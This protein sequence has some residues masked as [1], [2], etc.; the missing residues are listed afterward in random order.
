M[1]GKINIFGRI[2]ILV[3]LL[4]IPILLLYSISNR[5]ASD[6]VQEQLQTSS[7]NQL[8]FV[9]HQMDL[10]IDNLSMFPV[11]LGQDP[12]IRDYLDSPG[13]A[14]PDMLARQARITEKL[15][16]QSVSSTW[17]NDLSIVL[18]RE[19]KVLSSNIYLNGTADWA[20]EGEV[21]KGWTYE[22]DRTRGSPTGAFVR[23]VAEPALVR[24][25]ES[26]SALYHVSFP[27]RN[28][29]E[30]LDIYKKDRQSEPFLYRP[31]GGM[32]VSSTSDK[33][34]AGKVAAIMA[35]GQTLSAAGQMRIEL[36][37]EP[38]L[39]SFVRSGQ[40][41]GW[42]LVDYAPLSRVLAP[43][44]KTRNLFYVSVGLLL[45]M[46][47]LA[48]YL[49]YRNVQRPILN[50]IR[51]MQR[52]KR[53]DLSARIDYRARNEFDYLIVRF[54]EMAEQIQVLVE[55]VYAE[56]IRSREA[57]LKQLQSQINPHFLYNSL[58]FII[59]SA[60][61]DDRDSV[62]AMSQHLAEYFRYTTRIDDQTATL[63]DEI[64][65]IG[66]YLEIQSMRMHRLRYTITVPDE[67]KGEFV[68]RLIIQPLVENAIV[69][70]I[71]GS[72]DEGRITI[73]GEQDGDY[74]RI[75]V[76]DNGP[77]VSADEL[78]RLRG[79]LDRPMTDRIGRGTWNVHK[80]LLYQFGE[81]SGLTFS[82]APSGGLRAVLAWKRKRGPAALSAESER[83]GAEPPSLSY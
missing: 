29:S 23:E 63:G 11:I 67:L 10:I 52:L 20:W 62:V 17:S 43:I 19:R 81:G 41:E 2:L 31:E 21:R 68:P 35:P 51:S 71:E 50:L 15:G 26:A 77:G 47:T 30:L 12:H 32:I 49:L 28:I 82:R 13:G 79:S 65:L 14:L 36:G 75:I 46:S 74:N 78:E 37:G 3:S 53:G 8:T 18:P 66:H 33:T 39:V 22:A 34:A 54:N 7:L 38:V 1:P 44:A 64:E 76:D 59:N 61:M 56:K 25:V 27:E 83:R 42:Y 72:P 58:F 9:L 73:V 45:A 48:S 6:V 60:M 5:T 70:G 40:L 16:L 55:D 69:H 4:L 57:T 80:R 24:R